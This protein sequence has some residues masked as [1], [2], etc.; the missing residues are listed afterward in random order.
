[1][2]R[3]FKY[4]CIASKVPHVVSVANE[5]IKM[6][7]CVVIGLQSTGE[8]R[9]LEVVEREE[10][11]SDFV[12]TAKGVLQSLVEKH[13]PAPDRN[14]IDKILGKNKSLFEELG[15]PEDTKVDKDG[16][17]VLGKR[18]AKARAEAN[19]KKGRY[20]WM[21][22][23]YGGGGD[24]SSDFENDNEDDQDFDSMEEVHKPTFLKTVNVK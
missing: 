8:A 18:K 15:I 10:E 19:A 12:S 9:T 3:F 4:L 22:G 17:P 2:Q 7:K 23:T 21:T 11:L 1:M 20:D 13:F 5:V 6:G 24:G 14:K 16:A